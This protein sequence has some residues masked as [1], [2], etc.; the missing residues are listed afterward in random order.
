MG[1]GDKFLID[2]PMSTTV[3]LEGWAK[4]PYF[5]YM[6]VT[7]HLVTAMLPLSQDVKPEEKLPDFI[8]VHNPNFTQDVYVDLAVT[9]A[10]ILKWIHY[11]MKN[12]LTNR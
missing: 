6:E 11:W 3:L 2:K 7:L 4:I 12:L 9:S 10:S 5:Y 8:L 1:E